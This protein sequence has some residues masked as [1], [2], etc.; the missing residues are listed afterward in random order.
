M[1]ITANKQ[2][3]IG[4]SVFGEIDNDALLLFFEKS[5]NIKRISRTQ[6]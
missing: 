6:T 3:Y 5:N 4:Q 2:K 1:K